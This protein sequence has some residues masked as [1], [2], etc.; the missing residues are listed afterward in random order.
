MS[1]QDGPGQ[2]EPRH[3]PDQTAHGPHDVPDDDR[4]PTAG[5]DRRP[6]MHPDMERASSSRPAVAGA[7]ALGVIGLIVFILWTAGLVGG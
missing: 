7:I 3:H 6:G 4:A 1:A 2:D 5:A